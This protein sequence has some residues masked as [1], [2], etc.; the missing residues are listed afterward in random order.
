MVSQSHV[1]RRWRGGEEHHVVSHCIAS[2]AS[3]SH[4][5]TEPGTDSTTGEEPRRCNPRHA[6]LGF[7]S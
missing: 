3:A 7:D 6:R 5:D 1:V 4:H 2:L